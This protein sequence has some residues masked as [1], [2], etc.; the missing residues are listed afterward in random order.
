METSLFLTQWHGGDREALN[1]LLEQHLPWIKD[2]VRQ[3]M[4]PVLRNKGDTT[5]YVQDAMVQFLQYGPRFVISDGDHFRA[6]LLRIVENAV[7]DKIDWFTARRRD[8]ARERPLPTETVLHLDARRETEKT[9]S[10]YAD[11][12]EQEA[13]VRLGMEFLDNEDKKILVLHQWDQLSFVKIGERFGIS[14][15]AARKRHNRAVKRLS[16]AVWALRSGK[17]ERILS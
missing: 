6:L 7:R 2:R 9:P 4:G 15:N 1:R 10:Q 8:I 16:D 12:N 11:E 14:S 17:V 5:D 3:R 13:W